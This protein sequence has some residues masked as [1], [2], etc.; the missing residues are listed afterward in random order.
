M[1]SGVAPCCARR[2]PAAPSRSCASASRRCSVETYSSLR[3]SASACAR[4]SALRVRSPR[5]WPLPPVTVGSF[6]SSARRACWIAS[7]RAPSL[8]SSGPTTPSGCSTSATRTCSGSSAWWPSRS[9]SDCAACNPSCAFTVNL[10]SLMLLSPL[11]GARVVPPERPQL[12]VQLFL[13][14]AELARHDDP[15][16]HELV[17][18]A[19][20]LE[21]RH[22]VARQPEHAAARGR[23]RDLHRDLALERRHLERRAER[24]L[25]GG[26][27]QR[28][29]DVVALA[30]EHRVRG[31]GH[32]EVEVAAL[33][34]PAAALARDAHALAAPDAGG[35]LH[36]HLAPRPL[37]AVSV[38]RGARLALDVAA[39]VTGRARLVE[40]EREG[41][42]RASERLLERDLDRRLHV[43]ASAWPPGAEPLPGVEAGA[44]PRAPAAEVAEHGAE[45]L[46]EVSQVAGIALVLDP[47]PAAISCRTLLDVALPVGA[48]RVVAAALLAIRENLVGLADLLEPL[49]GVLGLGDIRV[50]L[51]RQLPVGGLDRLVVRVPVDTQ[52]PVIVLEF[53]AHRRLILQRI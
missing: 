38:T 37:P 22:P 1:A 23:R 4:S 40:V 13:R 9:A 19:R 11:V 26:D 33:P 51:A 8:A 52:N 16:R 5:Y 36:V 49:A 53:D 12:F 15:H 31:Y 28:Q 50:V 48:E 44:A 6:A 2:R 10:S 21:A 41:A 42:A 3:R 30:L 29:V 34:G 43:L 20:A 25:G 27:R 35:N 45:E 17:A 14:R 18:G 7:R 32:L 47:E 46:R 39:A 24:R